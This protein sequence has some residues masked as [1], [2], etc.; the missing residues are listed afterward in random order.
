MTP[1]D[2]IIPPYLK[3]L[4]ELWPLFT[5]LSALILGGGL[6]FLATKFVTHSRCQQHREGIAACQNA[7]EQR[8]RTAESRME[9]LPTA[10]N[11]S[12]LEL[13]IERLT[14]RVRGLEATVDGQRQLMERVER[15]LDRMDTYLRSVS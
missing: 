13:T 14:S 1:N 5:L 15:Q 12:A 10:Q 7:E 8:L 6:L 2:I 9:A 3:L 11:I 4:M